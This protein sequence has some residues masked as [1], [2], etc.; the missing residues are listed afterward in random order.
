LLNA[1]AQIRRLQW[2][3]VALLA[4]R[5][6]HLKNKTLLLIIL[7]SFL[8]RLA[9]VSFGVQDSP[10][11][12]RYA[13]AITLLNTHDFASVLTMY[14]H[15]GFTIVSLIPASF[16]KNIATL[17]GQ[18]LDNLSAIPVLILSL[19][20]VGI[21]ALTHGIA[22]RAGASPRE[23]LLAAFLAAITNS[24]FYWSPHFL[25]YDMGLCVA[26]LAL[27]IGLKPNPSPRRS[28]CVGL[29]VCCAFLIYNAYWLICAVVLVLHTLNSRRFDLRRMV[30]R[31]FFTGIGFALI[32]VLLAL[33]TQG[34]YIAGLLRFSGTVVQGAFSEGWSLPF[35]WMWYAE[36]LFLLIWLIG[37][38]NALI[39]STRKIER[40]MIFWLLAIVTIYI[41]LVLGSVVL[42]KFVVNGRIAR[43]LVPFMILSAAYGIDH[44]PALSRRF[45]TIAAVLIAIPN[46]VLPFTIGTRRGAELR[47][48]AEVGAFGHQSTLDGPTWWPKTDDRYILL[49]TEWIYPVLGLKPVPEGRVVFSIN[50]PYHF[51]ALM[52]EA[53]DPQMRAIIRSSPLNFQ[54]ALI[55]TG[56]NSP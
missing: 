7:A 56:D 53:L 10:D 46:L 6:V 16:Q 8:L 38:I 4:Y 31:G 54:M 1:L 9:L 43:Q 37:L 11:D 5:V 3:S 12:V 15:V 13:R 50:H 18:S 52:Y 35:E 41:V 44:L 14:D 20:S 28:F 32:L 36:R 27:Y 29:L 47:A 48:Q 30:L 40:R 49:N 25:P 2:G 55:D 33:T 17:T 39:I 42:Q 26:L 24:L 23:A 21:I 19:A 45:V 22:R 51:E 34:Q